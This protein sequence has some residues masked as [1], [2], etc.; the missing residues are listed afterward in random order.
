MRSFPRPDISRFLPPFTSTSWPGTSCSE[1]T[2]PTASCRITSTRFS[3][4]SHAPTAASAMPRG[5]FP[6]SIS[7]PFIALTRATANKFPPSVHVGSYSLF[8]KRHLSE[9]AQHRSRRGAPGLEVYEKIGRTNFH[10]RFSSTAP[11]RLNDA[12]R[13]LAD[14][15]TM[16]PR[17]Q[18]AFGRTDQSR[19]RSWSPHSLK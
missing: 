18:P 15:F 9:N 13:K 12:T 19:R 5:G 2:S 8:V 7:R 3:R 4:L 1:P 16:W 11:L 10:R 6:T 14:R 17:A